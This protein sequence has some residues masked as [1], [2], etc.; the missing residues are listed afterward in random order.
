MIRTNLSTRPFY[1]ERAVHVVAAILAVVLLALTV[2]QVGRVVRLSRY[3]TE[4]Q[5]VIKRNRAETESNTS[6]AQQIRRGLDQQQLAALA[7][8]AREANDLI[9]QRT[10][11]WTEI[12][13]QIEATLPGD[14]MLLGVQPDFSEGMTRLH[15]DVQGKSEEEIDAFWQRLEKTGS[16]RDAEWSNMTV[17]DETLRRVTMSVVYLGRPAGPRPASAAPVEKPAPSTGVRP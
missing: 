8:S 15:M 13:N 3:R 14:V 2:W 17:V 11:S 6:Q 9:A 5:T 16:F 1:N 7:A 10:F 4:L 12:F